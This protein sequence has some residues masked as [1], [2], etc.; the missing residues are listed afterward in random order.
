MSPR[1]R[2]A[3][4]VR[5]RQCA[6]ENPKRGSAASGESMSGIYPYKPV[7]GHVGAVQL[8]PLSR[9]KMFARYGRQN[10]HAFILSGP[11]TTRGPLS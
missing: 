8:R 7:S 4:A 9:L 5:A 3:P 1:R 11:T 2:A 10:I 6:L